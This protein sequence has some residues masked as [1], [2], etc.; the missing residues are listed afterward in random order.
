MPGP[1]IC[2]MKEAQDAAAGTMCFCP[3]LFFSSRSDL[4]LDSLEPLGVGGGGM[5]GG[6]INH[7][8]HMPQSRSPGLGK[9]P[10][11]QTFG[12]RLGIEEMG[13]GPPP[14][15]K[16]Y[17]EVPWRREGAQEPLSEGLVGLQLK[18]EWL[19]FLFFAPPDGLA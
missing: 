6:V 17:W 16:P 3:F 19:R 15:P 10:R 2:P 1:F 18:H 13:L 11:P 7:C 14:E 12:R 4:S 5:G 9:G 8:G